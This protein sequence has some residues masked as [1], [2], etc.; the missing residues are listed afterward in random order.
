[1]V[2]YTNMMNNYSFPGRAISFLNFVLA[3][4]KTVFTVSLTDR[5]AFIICVWIFVILSLPVFIKPLGYI[6]AFQFYFEG[7]GEYFSGYYHP[8]STHTFFSEVDS[9]GYYAYLPSLVIDHGFEWEKSLGPNWPEKDTSGR[10]TNNFTIGA[11]VMWLPFFLF[12]HLLSLV[13]N[14]FGVGVPL[15][16][17]SL[18][19]E[20]PCF[21]GSILYG[22]LGVILLYKI[23]RLYFNPKI[24]FYSAL[25]VLFSTPLIFYIEFEPSMSHSVGFFAAT[26]AIYFY[27]VTVKDKPYLGWILAGIFSGLASLIRLQCIS[28]FLCFLAVDF[29]FVVYRARKSNDLKRVVPHFFGWCLFVFFGILCLMPQILIWT[30]GFTHALELPKVP[31]IGWA[32]EGGVGVFANSYLTPAIIETLFHFHH[33]FFTWTPIAIPALV[34]FVC[35]LRRKYSPALLIILLFFLSQVYFVGASG[36]E[37]G[38]S[39]GQ[40]RLIET[41]VILG[42][43]LGEVFYRIGKNNIYYRSWLAICVFF[44]WFNLVFIYQWKFGFIPGGGFLNT[45]KELVF[46][47]FWIFPQMLQRAFVPFAGLFNIW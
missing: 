31:G 9:Q 33:G 8:M 21:F 35:L 32:R 16:G 20:L 36:W 25:L 37:S 38:W 6:P 22:C 45:F 1:M 4:V 10:V 42:L 11:A 44:V 30:G 41:F 24:S 47:K 26:A 15:N 14:F 29:C 28:L 34:G 7:L 39:F 17:Y 46:D 2:S 43:G 18:I 40:R 19:Y 23:C 12:G 13:L 27:M 5:K 3:K